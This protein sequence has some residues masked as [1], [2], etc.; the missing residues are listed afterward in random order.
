MTASPPTTTT[1]PT[2]SPLSATDLAVDHLLAQLA[3]SYRFLLD[4]TPAN[5]ADER[6]VFLSGD[7]EVPDF[8]Y[9]PLDTDPAVLRAQLDMVDVDA[10]D[11]PVLRELVTAKRR[12]LVVQAEMLD[13]RGTT[14]FRELSIEA[15]GEPDA[16]LVAQAE[17]L[18]D[19]VPT[20]S[21]RGNR[22][23]APEFLDLADTEIAAY[24]EHYP[25]AEMHAEIRDGV[26]GVVVEG[27]TLLISPTASVERGRAMALINHE[28]GTHLVTRVNGAAQQLQLLGTGFAGYDETQE[29]LAVLAEII[30]G[31]L[32]TGRLR[33]LAARV[34]AVAAMLRGADFPE[35]HAE[36]TRRGVPRGSA[37]TTTMRVH[38]SG[39][40][41]KDAAY[42]RGLIALLRHVRGGGTLEHC[43]VGKFALEDLPR[44]EQ[45]AAIGAISPPRLIPRYLE[46]P[47][48]A[49]RLATAASQVDDLARLANAGA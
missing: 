41:T 42:L 23:T 8:V 28:V 40:F 11:E 20:S 48:A 25:E 45:L 38:R 7:R 26:A 13:A 35:T 46:L 43:W 39:G 10:V 18:L 27:D 14:R 3:V 22:I 12:E 5:T 15:Y 47:H 17:R 32:T 16:A 29:G 31:E 33:Q 6:M 1:E 30:C 9:R 37:Y 34:I 19:T 36:L 4:I 44:I 24:A 49:E 21:D 2:T